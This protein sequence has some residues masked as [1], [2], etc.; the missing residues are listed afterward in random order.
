MKIALLDPA[1]FSSDRPSPNIGDHIISRASVRELKRLFGNNAEINRVPTHSKLT[2]LSYDVL[3]NADYII[4][5]GSNLL[6]FRYWPAASWPL[7]VFEFFKLRNV[8]LMGV[9]WGSYNIGAG[10]YSKIVANLVLSDKMLHSVRDGYT[11]SVV[12]EKLHIPN[13]LNTGCHTT[14]WMKD[15]EIAYVPHIKKSCIFTLTDY[16]Q[17]TV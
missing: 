8:I 17:D 2:K 14:W 10:R 7:G 16:A 9:G 5:G 1:L 12:Q 13:V 4:V 6:W 3:N 11:E 15:L